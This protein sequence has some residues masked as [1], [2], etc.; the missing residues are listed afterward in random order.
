MIDNTAVRFDG[1]ASRIALI[2]DEVDGMSGGDRGGV[3][4]LID[5]IKHSKIPIIAIC[6]DRYCQKL[7]SL[8][9]HVQEFKFSRPTKARRP[10]LGLAAAVCGGALRFGGGG[11]APSAGGADAL[12][13]PGLCRRRCAAG[14]RTSPRRRASS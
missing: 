10:A 2:M 7:K 3:A 5:S 4:D 8:L 11:P 14:C 6:N 1:K 9:N 13:W 12:A